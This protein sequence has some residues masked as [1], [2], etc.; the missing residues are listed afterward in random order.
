MKVYFS[1]INEWTQLFGKYN[2]TNWNWALVQFAYE[3][4]IILGAFELEIILLGIG[5]RI[6]ITKPIKTPEMLELEEQV[7]QIKAGTL[8]TIP[9]EEIHYPFMVG[10]CP[11]CYYKIDGSEEEVEE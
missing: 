3:N 2:W 5:V 6:R 10:R 7:K 11:R 9:W 8:K 1:F 4:D